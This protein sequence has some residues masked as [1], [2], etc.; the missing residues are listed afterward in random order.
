MLT[1]VL[2]L[3]PLIA[4]MLVLFTRNNTSRYVS[5]F[6]SALQLLFTFVVYFKFLGADIS[7][8]AT[9]ASF[10]FNKDWIQNPD[11]NFHIGL[12]GISL[13]M[14]FLTNLLIPLII[15]SGFNREQNRPHIL[16]A[17]ILFMQFALIGV[18]VSFDGI[19][20]YIFWEMALLPVY[21]IALSWGGENR[22]AITLKF[23]IY[24]LAGSL[25]M[26]FGFVLLYW[27][28]PLHNFDW[29]DLIKNPICSCNQGLVF[30]LFF[31]A[32]AIKIPVVPFHTWQPD[33]Y[34][35]A[36]TQGTMLLSG[37]MLKMG[38]YSL[39][40]WLLPVVPS[41]V[42]EW[43]P[44]VISLCVVGIIYTSVIAIMQ[45]DMKRLFAYSSIAHVGL[46][47]AGIFAANLQGMQGGF[48]QM[49][50]HGINV[51]GLFFCADIIM[52]RTGSNNVNGIGGIRLASPRFATYFFIIVLGTVALPL[53]N[54]FVGEFMLLYGMFE[55]NSWSAWL[56][57]SSVILGAVYMLRMY[58]KVMLG[59]SLEGNLEFGKLKWN[60]ELVLFSICALILVFG[61]F[62]KSIL[63]LVEP[64][65]DMIVK[66]S[67][68]K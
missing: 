39:V 11:I 68:I 49:L 42:A 60:E 4:S 16:Y 29:R 38:T 19:L 51:V 62:P 36:P 64:V 48:V 5:L 63:E 2:L 22:S 61:L 9:R 57:G 30:W 55:Y 28:N 10:I 35:T 66:K 6:I 33:T 59:E 41:G 25:L 31:I 21:F 17:L 20:Y 32:Y 34:H 23:F 8:E 14:V 1:L 27:Y 46:I 24:T 54:G 43:T 67:L 37:I 58:Q 40:R 53:T 65:G 44:M 56:A 13:L 26:L 3:I 50:A 52:N 45:S 18:F 15:L 47:T 7:N 12:D